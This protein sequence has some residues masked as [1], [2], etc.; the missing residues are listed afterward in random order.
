MDSGSVISLVQELNSFVS[1]CG[2]SSNLVFPSRWG[3]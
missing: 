1:S 2:L 3:E